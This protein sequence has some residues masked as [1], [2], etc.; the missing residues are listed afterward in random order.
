M[1]NS[2]LDRLFRRARQTVPD[3]PNE[4]PFGFDTRVLA[5][6]RSNRAR[7]LVDVGR[8]LRRVVL[9]S[10]AVIALASAGLYRELL[11]SDDPGELFLDQNEIADTAI[12]NAVEP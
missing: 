10:I 4:M 9:L 12:S 7:D 11:Q 1:K 8:L 3:M 2:A 6:W 5:L